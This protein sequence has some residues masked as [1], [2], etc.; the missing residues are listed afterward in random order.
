MTQPQGYKWFVYKKVGKDKIDD[1]KI[2]QGFKRNWMA[3]NQMKKILDDL[4]DEE[5]EKTDLYVW[6]ELQQNG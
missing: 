4:T 2:S 5:L 6:K 3:T 1:V